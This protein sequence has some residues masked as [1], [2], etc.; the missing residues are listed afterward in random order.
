MLARSG[1]FV[2]T[3]NGHTILSLSS[4]FTFSLSS[5]RLSVVGVTFSRPAPLLLRRLPTLLWQKLDLTFSG[6]DT[7]QFA[8]LQG[9]LLHFFCTPRYSVCVCVTEKETDTQSG[10]QTDWQTGHLLVCFSDSPN[11]AFF[12]F[13]DYTVYSQV[14]NK[15]GSSPPVIWESAVCVC[16]AWACGGSHMFSAVLS[17]PV[18]SPGGCHGN[19]QTA[20]DFAPASSGDCENREEV[21]RVRNLSIFFC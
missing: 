6:Y 2:F 16:S 21:L 3:I 15:G 20:A 17:K 14:L 10:K 1:L 8:P 12:Y 18:C 4:Q 5:S 13:G 7:S 9:S 11:I 19:S